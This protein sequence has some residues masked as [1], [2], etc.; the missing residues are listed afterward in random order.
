VRHRRAD[1]ARAVAEAEAA[2]ANDA[3][4]PRTASVE[5]ARKIIAAFAEANAEG[6]GVTVVDGRLVE[7]LHVESARRTLMIHD[8]IEKMEAD[9]GA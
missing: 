6:R 8:L 2:G 3:F 1:E 7:T 4:T 9:H 5:R